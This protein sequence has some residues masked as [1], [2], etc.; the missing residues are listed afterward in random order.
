[1]VLLVLVVVDV[2][3][4]LVGPLLLLHLEFLV[5]L[6]V[7]LLLEHQFLLCQQMYL[8]HL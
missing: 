4:V 5:V 7:Q 3:F 1:M 6:L 2:L 8:L